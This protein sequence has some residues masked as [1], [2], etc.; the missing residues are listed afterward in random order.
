MLIPGL[1]L[2]EKE[3]CHYDRYRVTMEVRETEK[4]YIFKLIELKSRYGAVHIERFFRKSERVLPRKNK[5]GD[6][7]SGYGATM[8]SHSIRFRRAFHITSKCSRRERPHQPQ[9]R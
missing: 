9:S 4:S 7:P 8:I 5:G 2:A 6:T 1:Y 3:Y